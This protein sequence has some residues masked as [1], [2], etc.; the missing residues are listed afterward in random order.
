MEVASPGQG[1]NGHPSTMARVP[2]LDPDAVVRH[3]VDLLEVTLGATP[4]DLEAK[5]SLL[6]DSKKQDTLGRCTRFASEPQVALYVQKDIASSAV[7]N[8]VLNGH[9]RTGRFF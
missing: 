7:Q 5:G 3:L 2:T 4:E 8:G 1:V 9:V 6:S